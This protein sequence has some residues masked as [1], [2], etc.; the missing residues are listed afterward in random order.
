MSGRRVYFPDHI[1][2]DLNRDG[3]RDKNSNSGRLNFTDYNNPTR[4]LNNN[5]EYNSRRISSSNRNDNSV[6]RTP[7]RVSSSPYRKGNGGYTEATRAYTP[8]TNEGTY[9]STGN[10]DS[11]GAFENTM[12]SYGDNMYSSNRN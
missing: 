9:T 2:S 8:N 7:V 3:S 10:K 4:D 11:R 12:G 5:N 6:T 1:Y